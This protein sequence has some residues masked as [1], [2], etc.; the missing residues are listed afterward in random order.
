MLPLILV[1]GWLLGKTFGFFSFNQPDIQQQMLYV[2]FLGSVLFGLV[3]TTVFAPQ[4]KLV[5]GM[6]YVMIAFLT[7]RYLHW[8]VFST[9]NLDT[10]INGFL[11]VT[12]IS[13]ELLMLLPNILANYMMLVTRTDHDDEANCLAR[14]VESGQYVPSVDIFIATYN[15]AEDMLER[16]IMGC[17]ALDYPNKKIYVLDDSKREH[18][19]TL[20]QKLGCGYFSRSKRVSAYRYAASYS[21]PGLDNKSA[22]SKR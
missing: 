4:N 9:L 2:P 7:L 19:R 13:A 12:L 1:T 21:P 18:V 3:L 8:R 11:S 22:K 16:T 17:Q 20:T 14:H 5:R 15:E 6:V 10:P